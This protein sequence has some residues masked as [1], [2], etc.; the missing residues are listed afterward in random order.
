MGG[1]HHWRRQQ[2]RG[3]AA[4]FTDETTGEGS[5][6]MGY[7]NVQ[8]GDAPYFTKLADEYALDDNFHQAIEGGT[9]ANHIFVGYGTAIFYADSKGNPATPPSNQIENPNAQPG[10]NNW[11]VQDGYGGGSY[12]GCADATQP[13]IGAVRN[14]EAG[15]KYK[16]LDACRKGAY[17]LVNNYNP[18][19]FGTGVAAPLGANVFTIPGST[20]NNIALELNAHHVS[21]K[22]YGEGWAG[23]TE[24]GE[25]STYCNICNPFLYSTQ[26]MTNPS[27]R[28]NLQDVQDLYNDIDNTTLPAVSIVKPD[29]YL[30]GHPASSKWDLYEGFVK[31]IVDKIKANPDVWKNTV[32]FITCDE[33]GGY[34]DS[35]YIQPLD[36]FGDGTRIPLLIVS[37]FTEHR[38]IV[39]AYGDHV[40]FPKFVEANWGLETL[41]DRSR[42][43]LPNPI[44][45]HENPWVPVN[46]PALSDLME[47]FDFHRR[48]GG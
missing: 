3:A 7:W 24:T 18:G 20:Q 4:G 37:P 34:Y 32:I 26:I 5:T 39:H 21:W 44:T 1:N 23:G 17:Y 29:G 25:N 40:S 8:A 41:S 6:A 11:W 46:S 9:G 2:W 27:L 19:Y 12:V 15:L 31:K 36:F 48:R 22:Y 35:G 10:T 14:Y 28:K 43:N 16:V 47:V 42:D 13:G 33:G 45:R 30:D 38:G